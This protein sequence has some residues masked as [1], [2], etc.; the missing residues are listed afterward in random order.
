MRKTG[1]A[2]SSLWGKVLFVVYGVKSI[3][4][5]RALKARK[6]RERYMSLGNFGVGHLAFLHDAHVTATFFA[7]FAAAFGQSLDASDTSCP[8]TLD[9][10]SEG[11]SSLAADNSDGLENGFPAVSAKYCRMVDPL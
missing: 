9:R 4:S 10:G 11:V 8:D 5:I 2:M 6:F 3:R 1:L 7:P